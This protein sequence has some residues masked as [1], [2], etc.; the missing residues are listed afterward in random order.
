MNIPSESE[1]LG[2]TIT[3]LKMSLQ[4]SWGYFMTVI[5]IGDWFNSGNQFNVEA[6][7]FDLV[8]ES[9]IRCSI[10]T[11]AGLIANNKDA[12]HFHYFLNI[13]ND[14]L[15]LFQFPEKSK[16]EKSIQKHRN[17]LKI[18]ISDGAIGNRIID[19][20]NKIIAHLDRKFVTQKRPNFLDN[21]PSLNSGELVGVY[22]QLMNI[23]SEIE[24]FYYDR[25]FVKN[26][27]DSDI[28]GEI[29][30]LFSLIGKKP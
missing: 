23:I 13:A 1:K 30:Q 25:P 20:R 27:F 24:A 22:K 11:L 6:R 15:S 8:S 2:D 18:L 3:A 17:W 4:E 26:N 10:L 9:C 19:K 7:F 12:V 21:N 28:K 29:E 5:Y 14:S 16:I